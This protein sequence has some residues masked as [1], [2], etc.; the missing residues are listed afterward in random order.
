MVTESDRGVGSHKRDPV[1]PIGVATK[2]TRLYCK[3]GTRL[4]MMM[5]NDLPKGRLW[6]I[7][8][9]NKMDNDKI[10]YMI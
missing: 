7:S 8:M 3:T 4:M 5:H 6:M 1:V 9:M 2:L 10:V